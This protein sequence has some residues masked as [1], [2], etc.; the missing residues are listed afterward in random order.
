MMKRISIFSIVLILAL[1]CSKNNPTQDPDPTPTPIHVQT[2]E[3][4]DLGLSVKWASFNI[5]AGQNFLN[6]SPSTPQKASPKMLPD[7]LEVPSFRLTKMT[8]TSLILKP[9]L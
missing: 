1:S 6:L 2:P 5:G 8:G 9:F 4:V 3:I 7:I